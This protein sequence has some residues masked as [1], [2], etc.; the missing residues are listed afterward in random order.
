MLFK[1]LVK[2]KLLIKGDLVQLTGM[3]LS[4]RY[5]YGL[6]LPSALLVILK[7]AEVVMFHSKLAWSFR[8]TLFF[9]FQ[10]PMGPEI[11]FTLTET[12]L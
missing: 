9:M 7:T 6:V 10:V 11:K 2:I 4:S 5:S 1:N 8:L 3:S 12:K